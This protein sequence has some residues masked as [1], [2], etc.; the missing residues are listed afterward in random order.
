MSPRVFLIV[1]PVAGRGRAVRTWRR[2]E[3]LVPALAAESGATYE[4]RYTERPQHAAELARRA[5]ADGFD[6]VAVVGGDGT[7]NEVGN[8]LVGT[9]AALAII[10]AGTANDLVRTFPIPTKPEEALRVAFQGRAAKLDAGLAET[11]Q[12]R[13]HFINMFGAGFDAEAAALVNDIGPLVKRFGGGV[14]IPVCVIITLARYRFPQLTVTVDG[15][16][17][18]VPR[19]IFS[20]VAIGKYIGNGMKLLPD[21]VPDDGL[22]DV[23]WAHEMG[24]LEILRTVMKTYDGSHVGH[25]RIH[26]C[27]GKKVRLESSTSLRCHLDGEAGGTLPATIE[28]VPG[29]LGIVLPHK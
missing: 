27:R 21:A 26:F 11:S 13:R 10:P 1:N 22:F 15:A 8:G 28:V 19:V 29:A 18:E 4:V 5:A 25:P 2:I 16:T 6:R 3:P 24:R 7:L 20:A 12:V 17:T 23:T 14:A 9:G